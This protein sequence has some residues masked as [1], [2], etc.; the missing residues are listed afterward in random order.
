MRDPHV[1]ALLYR[2]QA[3][4][5]LAFND[6]APLERETAAFSVRL[7]KGQVRI[8][9]KDHFAKSDAARREVGTYLHSWEIATDLK[10]GSWCNALP[11]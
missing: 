9:M 2:L 8:E 11:I 5:Q 1:V 6:P 7:T 10:N 3:G 4:P